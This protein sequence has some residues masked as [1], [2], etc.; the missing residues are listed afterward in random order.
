[1][2]EPLWLANARALVGLREIVGSVHEPKVVAFFAAAGHPEIHDDETAWCAAFVGA[3]LAG[4]SIAGTRSLSAR[5]YER[6]GTAVTRAEARPGDVVT[7]YRGATPADWEGHVAFFLAWADG[8]KK[9]QVLGGNQSNSVSIA[10]Y[11]ASKIT[12]IRRP[13][14]PLPGT[15]FDTGTFAAEVQQVQLRLN[16]LGFREVGRADGYYGPLTLKALNAFRAA[17]GLRQFDAYVVT[18]EDRA[19]LFA[20]RQPDDPGPPP[21]KPLDRNPGCNFFARLFPSSRKGA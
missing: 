9:V 20:R 12:S 19:L 15:L 5:S 10:L 11:D 3:M 17:N 14:A 2:A 21:P 4:A 16:E 18:D 1:M 13:P 7:F 8:G 6:W